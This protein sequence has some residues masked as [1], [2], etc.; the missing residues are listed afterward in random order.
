[1]SSES[2]INSDL[3]EWKVAKEKSNRF[4]V[5]KPKVRRRWDKDP[6]TRVHRPKKGKGSYNRQE[7]KLKERN[8][9]KKY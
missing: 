4:T 5:E 2:A 3:K 7:E 6:S 1:V 8:L 9:N